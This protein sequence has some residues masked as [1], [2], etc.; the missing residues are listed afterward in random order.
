LHALTTCAGSIRKFLDRGGVIVWGI[1]PTGFEAFSKESL[2]FLA[3]KLE[4][5]WQHLCQK[6]LD[7]EYLLSRSMLSPATCCLVNQ[8]GGLTVAKAFALVNQLSR[9]LREKYRIA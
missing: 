7:F 9:M 3:M 4:G 8:D 1:I 5:I 2:G 6:N